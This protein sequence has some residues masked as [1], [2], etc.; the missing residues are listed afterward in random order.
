GAGD[1]GQFD[2]RPGVA[3][4][5]DRADLADQRE[6][7]RVDDQQNDEAADVD[8]DAEP[9]QRR[10]QIP[11]V[12]RDRLA[13]QTGGSDRRQADDPPQRL[14]DQFEDRAAEVEERLGLLADREGRGAEGDPQEDD[15]ENVELGERRDDV[16]RDDAGEEVDPAADLLGR[17]GVRRTQG[18]ALTWVDDQAEADADDDGDQGGGHEPE[19]RLT[20]QPG[21]AF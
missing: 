14:L 21:R 13:D 17:F 4:E 10:E 5:R 19:Q 16:R 8:A 18:D 9:G 6:Q 12:R 2:R 20:R 1:E 15:L 3:E 7:H 11:P